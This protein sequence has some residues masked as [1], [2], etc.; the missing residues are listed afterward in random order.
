MSFRLYES[1]GCHLCELA[2]QLVLQTQIS[3]AGCELVDIAYEQQLM[4]RFGESIPVLE[5]IQSGH[6]IH[7]PFDM[8]HL[9]SWLKQF[10]LQ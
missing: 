7:W 6:C 4:D 5:H 8:A 9:N 1:E 10:D 3:E 2:K